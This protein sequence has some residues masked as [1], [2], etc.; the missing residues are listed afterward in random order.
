MDWVMTVEDWAEIRRLH[1]QEQLSIRAIAKHLGIA[2]DTVARAVAAQLPP[3]YVRPPVVSRFDAYEPRVR[4]LLKD[5]PAMPATVIAERVGW[6]G[7]ASWFRK[8]VAG[9]RVEYAPRDP[10]DRLEY[11]PGDQAQCDLW[12]P[13]VKIPLGYGQCGSP[14]VLVIVSSYS[15]F[16]TAMMLPSRTTGDLLAGMWELMSGQLGA[17]PHRLIW[18]NEAGIGRRN[19]YAE[20]VAGFCGT[21][22]TRIVQLRAFDPESK[23]I[24]ERANGYLETSF[25]PG[26]TFTSPADFNTQLGQWLPVAN[27]R[28]VRRL[29]ARPV[30]LAGI[31]RAAMLALPP[32]PPATGFGARVR[33][34]RDYYVR[35]AG[36]DYSVDPVVIGRMVEVHADL[37]TV[38][39]TCDGRAVAT[40]PRC[41]ATA[42]TITDPDHVA[43]ARRLWQAILAPPAVAP[44]AL[45]RDLAD[46]DTAFGVDL[47]TRVGTDGQVA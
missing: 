39:V 17:V 36:N 14:P 27:R 23:G 20:G 1:A 22:A 28:T 25:L 38:T 3:Q 37:D 34:P 24:V 4:E 31:D 9:L 16:I 47:D 19:R 26:R 10:A 42:Q 5:F 21:L 30:E 6:D 13:P 40:H 41:W 7:S 29:G 2:R 43:T 45:L 15:R 33:L 11:R 12:F 46:Y 32:M 18:D 8:Q 44:D 35:V